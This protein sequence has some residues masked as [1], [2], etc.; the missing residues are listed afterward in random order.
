MQE[1]HGM[2][3][4]ALHGGRLASIIGRNTIFGVGANFARIATRIITVPIVIKYLGLDG[5]GIWSIIMV[6]AAY[7]RFGSA[8][9]K[10]AYQKYVA[11][12]TGSGDFE[13]AN[14]LISTGS[15]LMLALSVVGLTPVVI[16]STY[17][18]RAAGVPSHFLAS[19]AGSI[20]L[21]AL[22]I[23]VSN[24]GAGYEA[25]V[26]G[27]QRI[28]LVKTVNIIA[29]IGEAVAIVLLLHFGR[30]L[31]AMSAV[32]ATSELSYILYCMVMSRRILPQIHIAAKYVTRTVLRDFVSFAGS[33]QLVSVQEVVYDAILPVAVLKFFGPTAAGAFAVVGRL[34]QAALMP[35]DAFLIPILSGSSL[36]FA[37]GST[38]Q[39]KVLIMKAFKTTFGLS[40]LPLAIICASGTTILYAW[41]GQADPS[42]HVFLWLMSLAGLFKAMSL[43]QLV[44]YRASGKSLMDNIRQTIRIVILLV[45]GLMGKHLGLMGILAGLAFAELSGMIFMFF[46]LSHGF[47]W[48]KSRI[49]LPDALKFTAAA[50]ATALLSVLVV[51]LPIPWVASARTVALVRVCMIGVLTLA[52]AVPVL[53]R[54]GALSRAE[55]RTI[56]DVLPSRRPKVYANS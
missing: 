22:I 29:T 38:E 5:Y 47:Q 34:V 7:M 9:I 21:L 27:A 2:E 24:V 8:G 14:K 43:L 30:G 10:C 32:M 26:T 53:L 39:M 4:S 13:K 54:T 48:F 42:F 28:D 17:L 44:L 46:A 35:Q 55:L 37:S 6:T 19:A 52:A 12:A 1:N 3:K 45:I 40:V 23:L 49:L 36:V 18:A 25:I 16:F 50:M 33:Y 31:L 20:S 51:Y 11:E 41:T 56:R 15:A